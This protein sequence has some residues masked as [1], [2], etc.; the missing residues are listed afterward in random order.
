MQWEC[1]ES[2]PGLLQCHELYTPSSRLYISEILPLVC[3]LLQHVF[4]ETQLVL[5]FPKY[6]SLFCGKQIA[7]VIYWTAT[8]F[9]FFYVQ[10][11]IILY[12]LYIYIY[13]IIHLLA[14]TVCPPCYYT[15]SYLEE[16]LSNLKSIDTL[17]P[18]PYFLNI[19]HIQMGLGSIV[20]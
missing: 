9:A 8:Q 1:S 10:S 7:K 2:W 5:T 4:S 20:Q 13:I 6:T 18:P 14:G 15:L 12:V 17:V 11:T 16:L 3:F 19:N